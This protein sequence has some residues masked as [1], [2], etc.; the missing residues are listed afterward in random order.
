MVTRGVDFAIKFA[1][2][3]NYKKYHIFYIILT[4]V[5]GL[6]ISQCRSIYLIYFLTLIYGVL[7]GIK[8]STITKI[9]TSNK[10]YEPYCFIEEE[11]SQ[12][13]GGTLG[14]IVSQFI[15]DINPF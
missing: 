4:L 8:N 12:V 10:E 11:R 6:I 13:I 14:L 2:K 3:V 9:N 15:Y 1:L 7:T 5:L